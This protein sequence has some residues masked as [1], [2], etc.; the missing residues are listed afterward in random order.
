MT[1]HKI[2]L[3]TAKHLPTGSDDAEGLITA[4]KDVG[5]C[6]SITIWSDPTVDWAKF[7]AVLMH[8]PWDYTDRLKEF[9][10]WVNEVNAKSYL[11]NGN[12]FGWNHDK[13]Y[14]LELSSRGIAIPSSIVLPTGR[15]SSSEQLRGL[16]GEGILVIKPAVGAGGRR[17][18]KCKN[19][20]TANQLLHDGELAL[21][22]V[23]V[24]KYEPAITVDGEYSTVVLGGEVSHTVLKSAHA[25]EF[26]VQDHYGGTTAMVA[27]PTGAHGLIEHLMAL[28]SEMP[29]YARI[30]YIIRDTGELVLMEAELI[31][32]DLFLRLHK[33]SFQALA[34]LSV[35][36]ASRKNLRLG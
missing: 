33:P 32:P 11:V 14:L 17:A 10:K 12:F 20:E 28:L 1:S 29:I 13:S 9:S 16:L 30:D 19:V 8:T 34:R 27:M 21:T 23:L 4:L 25:G 5:L 6:A 3:A 26:R 31:E 36:A 24:Q 35:T 15:H 18:Y 22:K 2:A 7:D